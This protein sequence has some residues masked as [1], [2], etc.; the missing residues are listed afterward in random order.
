MRRD[1]ALR[2]VKRLPH[3]GSDLASGSTTTMEKDYAAQLFERHEPRIARGAARD[4]ARRSLNDGLGA[5]SH[6]T[7][8]SGS[9]RF[10][11]SALSE[12]TLRILALIGITN[13]PTPR[14][15]RRLRGARRMASMRPTPRRGSQRCSMEASRDGVTQFIINTAFSA[16]PR[17]VLARRVAHSS[18][19][20][21]HRLASRRFDEIDLQTATCWRNSTS[22]PRH[23]IEGQRRLQQSP[24]ATHDS[25]EATSSRCECSTFWKTTRMRSSS[26]HSFGGSRIQRRC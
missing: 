17:P 25:S 2:E 4:R 6:S 16:V 13:S 18:L 26:H 9:V 23:R 10:E 1:S 5:S 19:L 11:A 3:D 15:R 12:G 24:L 22:R 14:I 20:Q 7:S 21:E 8:S